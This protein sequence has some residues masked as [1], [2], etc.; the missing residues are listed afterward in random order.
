MLSV[1]H[2]MAI[3][4]PDHSTWAVYFAAITVFKAQAAIIEVTASS[5]GGGFSATE[6]TYQFSDLSGTPVAT[7]IG[8]VSNGDI[9]A[10]GDLKTGTGNGMDD[11]ASRLATAEATIANLTASVDLPP[12]YV[13]SYSPQ[14]PVQLGNSLCPAGST[15]FTAMFNF[16]FTAVGQ[17]DTDLQFVFTAGADVPHANWNL[18]L[19]STSHGDVTP[20][21]GVYYELTCY[22]EGVVA[23]FPSPLVQGQWYHLAFTYDGAKARVYFDGTILATGTPTICT[24]NIQ[25]GDVYFGSL[26]T[27]APMTAD[28]ARIRYWHG[29]ALTPDRVHSLKVLMQ[30]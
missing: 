3:A 11:L 16:R 21:G 19:L 22:G 17:L 10:S 9:T 30:P 27:R 5:G 4:A 28:M 2:L 25:C 8:N 26:F 29:I 12:N 7:L 20:N 18:R 1:V 15:A 24:P 6:P 23:M 14:G 13:G